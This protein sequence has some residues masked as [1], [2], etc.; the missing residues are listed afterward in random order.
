[1]SKWWK[2]FERSALFIYLIQKHGFHQLPMDTDDKSFVDNLLRESNDTGEIHRFLGAYAYLVDTFMKAH[3]DSFYVS[4]PESIPRA[5]ISTPSFS[6]AELETISQ[7]DG[8]YLK[9]TE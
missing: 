1:M 6:K 5:P 7:Y 3:S 2:I 9:M 4:I 8:N